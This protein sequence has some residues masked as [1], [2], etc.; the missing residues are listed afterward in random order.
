MPRTVVLVGSLDSKGADFAFVKRLIEQQGLRALVV[1]VGV[2]GEPVFKPD[3]AAAE[4]AAAGGGDWARLRS[5]E[6]KDEAMSVMAAGLAIVVRRLFDEGRLDGILGMGGGGGTSV[7]TAAMRAL[8]VGVPKLM[9]ST[10]ASG[11]ISPYTGT[12]DITF[13]P[14]VVDVAGVNRISRLIY[15]NAAGAIV[16]M[17][18]AQAP[19]AS[20]DR[21]L[22]AASMF[23]NTT[24][25]VQR[26]RQVVEEQDYEV[27]VF[28]A[29]GTGGRTMESL[30]ADGHIAGVLDLTTTELADHVCG[31]VLSAGPERLL[32]AAR[33]GV[34]AVIAPG[35]V[36]MANFWAPDTVPE[37]YR[38]RTF[39]QWNPDVTLMR[40]NVAENIAIGRLI[41]AAANAS[42]G[43]VA[44]LLPWRGVSMLDSEGSAFWDPAADQACY[45]TIIAALRPGIP[46][47]DMDVHINDPA[48][49][50]R[51]AA[52]LLEMMPRQ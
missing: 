4:V 6:H 1:D 19:A 10:L 45:S 42:T 50:D 35:C 24:A 43:P 37:R 41:A 30:I 48:F 36:D 33:R 49:A 20:E 27:L 21:P 32:A 25:C 34:P 8:P 12:R 16:G 47:I 52:V 2:L 15:R 9:V 40:T 29:T 23:G 44:I 51:A 18:Q 7:A 28:H 11:D 46:V 17:V 13:M 31:G 39:Y 26:A 22:V 14:A 5:G 3:I 38:D